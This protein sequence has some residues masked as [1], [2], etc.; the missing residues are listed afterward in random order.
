[1]ATRLRFEKTARA[2]IAALLLTLPAT[3]AFAQWIPGVGQDGRAGRWEAS[4]QLRFLQSEDLRFQGGSS[5]TL[6]DETAFGFTF[7][8]NFSEQLLIGGEFSFGS[9]D[10]RGTLLSSDDPPEDP[11]QLR[12]QFDT[13]AIGAVG[14]WHFVPGPLTPYASAGIGWTWV[15]TNIAQGP[16]QFGCWWDPWFGR[17]CGFFQNTTT[18]DF[19]TYKLGVGLR[20]D[21]NTALFFRGG[22]EQSWL[23]LDRV[24]GSNDVGAFRLEIGSRF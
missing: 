12:G 14:T 21:V 15:D 20:W 18:E 7:G 16:P 5:L 6:D 17:I 19:L 10:Y 1:M 9:V 3:V 24:S 11:L 8:Y 22:Y 4:A 2:A 13:A 23:D